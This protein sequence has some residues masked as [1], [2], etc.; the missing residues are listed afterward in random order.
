[1]PKL[2]SF[3]VLVLLFA[4]VSSPVAQAGEKP[5]TEV[6]SPNFRVLT[7]GS[8]ADGRRVAREFEQMRAVFAMGFP[9]CASRPARRWSSSRLAMSPP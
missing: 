7:N 6:R 3:R 9:R 5:W 1:M 4:G 2:R 8:A